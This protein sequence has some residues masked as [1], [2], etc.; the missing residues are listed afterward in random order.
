MKQE[1]LI[2]TIWRCWRCNEKELINKTGIFHSSLVNGS[3]WAN[4]LLEDLHV[5]GELK[6][7]YE[8]ELLYGKN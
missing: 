6:Q 8:R 5:M 2:G 4:W 1:D 3:H 7:K